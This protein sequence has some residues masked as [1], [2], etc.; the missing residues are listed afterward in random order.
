MSYSPPSSAAE[1]QGTPINFESDD[2]R[3]ETGNI[4]TMTPFAEFNIN[5]VPLDA[6]NSSMG[7]FLLQGVISSIHKRSATI[8]GRIGF[9]YLREPGNRFLLRANIINSATFSQQASLVNDSFFEYASSIVDGRLFVGMWNDSLPQ[10]LTAKKIK[11]RALIF[12][13][14]GATIT[15]VI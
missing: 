11:I 7:T 4:N 1:L 14:V 12:A 13:P 8:N 6:G 2:E 5:G 15:Q 3:T 10:T 9:A